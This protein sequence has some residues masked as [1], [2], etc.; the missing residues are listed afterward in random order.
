MSPEMISAW[1]SL[2]P[3]MRAKVSALWCTSPTTIHCMACSLR[4]V[5]PGHVPAAIEE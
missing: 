1:A 5:L 2:T 4:V 3:G